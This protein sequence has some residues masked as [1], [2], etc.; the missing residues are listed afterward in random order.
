M[1]LPYCAI[2]CAV[3][4]KKIADMTVLCKMVMRGA[5]FIF[6][7]PTHLERCISVWEDQVVKGSEFFDSVLARCQ[8][9]HVMNQAGDRIV[10]IEFPK[11]GRVRSRTVVSRSRAR[12][13]GKYPSFKMGRMIQWESNNELNAYRLLDATPEV[14]AYHEQPLTIRF[15]LNGEPHIHYPDVLV[16]SRPATWCNST[17]RTG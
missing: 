13:T 11:D 7:V 3:G 8:R 4:D 16:R 15:T 2:R 12:P 17:A 5:V 14:L 10:E 1:A 6:F 9:R